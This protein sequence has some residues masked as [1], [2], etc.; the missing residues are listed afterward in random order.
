MAEELEDLIEHSFIR[1]QETA[2]HEPNYT[3][4]SW[5]AVRDECVSGGAMDERCNIVAASLGKGHI[6]VV[7]MRLSCGCIMVPADSDEVVL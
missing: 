1:T 3:N 6:D 4:R 7:S 2:D 5:E